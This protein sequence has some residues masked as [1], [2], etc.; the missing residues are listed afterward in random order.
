MKKSVLVFVKQDMYGA[1]IYDRF[2]NVYYRIIRKAIPN[3]PM[4]TSWKEKEIAVILMD[5]EFNYLGETELGPEKQWHW[6]N[7]FVTEEGLNIEYLDHND[8]NEVNLTLK[9]FVPKKIEEQ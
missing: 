3:A 1:I 9:I 6:Q 5:E 7:S 8:I 2:R 4:D